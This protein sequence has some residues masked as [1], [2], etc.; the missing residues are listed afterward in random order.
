LRWAAEHESTALVV[1]E[2]VS[3][4]RERVPAQQAGEGAPG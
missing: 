1:V 4:S 3:L 2:W